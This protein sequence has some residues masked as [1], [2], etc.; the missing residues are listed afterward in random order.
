MFFRVIADFFAKVYAVE[1]RAAAL[2]C[3]YF[4]LGVC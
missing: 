1:R 4:C 3:I 2:M